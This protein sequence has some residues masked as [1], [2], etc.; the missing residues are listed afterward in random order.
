MSTSAEDRSPGQVLC[1]SF[2]TP[3]VSLRAS[4]AS[5]PNNRAMSKYRSRKSTTDENRSP[6]QMTC[7][8][9]G[10]SQGSSGSIRGPQLVRD[11][12]RRPLPFLTAQSSHEYRYSHKS[13]C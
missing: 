3:Q 8:S 9:S 10:T 7:T 6:G 1:S 4:S 12:P 13:F 11:D 5:Q 2:G